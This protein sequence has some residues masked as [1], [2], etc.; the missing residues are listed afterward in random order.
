MLGAWS[1]AT[2]LGAGP[3]EPDHIIQ[4]AAIVRGQFD[5]P[6]NHT[7]IGP[8]ANVSVPK[9]VA[10]VAALPGCFAFR[11]Q[12]SAGCAP[13][14]VRSSVSTEASTQFSHYPPL[15]YV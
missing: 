14:L 6:E 9:W 10:D 5:E 3:D 2:P 12:K 1:F 13:K 7:D 15:Y 4:A 11:P 8:L